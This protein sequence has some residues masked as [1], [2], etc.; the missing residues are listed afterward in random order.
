MNELKNCDINCIS[1]NLPSLSI[2]K[3]CLKGLVQPGTTTLL[4][5][6]KSFVLKVVRTAN[7]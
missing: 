5:K 6:F 1:G 2:I 4:S 3:H 7:I